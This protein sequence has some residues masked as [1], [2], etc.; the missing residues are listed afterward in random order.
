MCIAC[1]RHEQRAVDLVRRGIRVDGLRDLRDDA[2]PDAAPI[3]V[4]QSSHEDIASIQLTQSMSAEAIKS[5]KRVLNPIDRVSEVVF[6]LI[7][8]LTFTGSVSVANTGR[9][10]P[11]DGHWCAGLQSG[12]G[13]LLAR[14][15]QGHW[16][17]RKSAWARCSRRGSG[18]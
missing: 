9:E 2:L 1:P 7:M 11:H 15:G 12:L 8:V 3:L 18:C 17:C 4:K 6:G 13:N 5:S 14:E 16:S 10:A